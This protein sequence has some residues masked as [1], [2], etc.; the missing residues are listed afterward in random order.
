MPRPNSEPGTL[1]AIATTIPS[2]TA[3]LLFIVLSIPK[4]AHTRDNGRTSA[5]RGVILA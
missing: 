4:R 3:N 1:N 5:S 2:S